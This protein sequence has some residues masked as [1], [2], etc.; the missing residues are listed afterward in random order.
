MDVE[1]LIT[2]GPGVDLSILVENLLNFEKNIF[3]RIDFKNLGVT[4]QADL[5]RVKAECSTTLKWF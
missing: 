2:L 3:F 5:F 1:S 4:F